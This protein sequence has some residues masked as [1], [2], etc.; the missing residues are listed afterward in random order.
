MLPHINPAEIAFT[1]SAHAIIAALVVLIARNILRPGATS[2]V[3]EG[4]L[5]VAVTIAAVIALAFLVVPGWFP[6]VLERLFIS[7]AAARSGTPVPL[8]AIWPQGIAIAFAVGAFAIAGVIVWFDRRIRRSLDWCAP[9]LPRRPE[10]LWRGFLV[11]IVAGGRFAA[12]VAGKIG[13]R[14]LAA[15][16]AAIICLLFG[17]LAVNLLTGPRPV[18]ALDL[19]P[20]G[21]FAICAAAAVLVAVVQPDCKRLI[22]ILPM[23]SLLAALTLLAEGF[24]DLAYLLILV[25][26]IETAILLVLSGR[27]AEAPT[28]TDHPR[29]A[30]AVRIVLS[31]AGGAG[32]TLT[33]LAVSNLSL[34][35]TNWTRF[36]Q[37]ELWASILVLMLVLGV[38][39]TDLNRRARQPQ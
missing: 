36:D 11:R 23:A 12:A 37:I 8:G 32:A 9:A 6:L 24:A 28:P 19:V 1:I 25:L 4:K 30:Q 3:S 15:S 21:A 17:W 27:S 5:S 29:V 14:P 13:Y 22:A 16:L 38:I 39:A 35:S 10:R 7:A 20:V 18:I 31:L 33:G 26:V 34:E 2:A